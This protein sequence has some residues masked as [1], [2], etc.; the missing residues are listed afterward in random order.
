MQILLD[1]SDYR[2]GNTGDV[3]MLQVAILRLR[4]LWPQARI[5]VVTQDASAL[6]LHCPGVEPL[7]H[8]GRTLWLSDRL[9]LGS[10]HRLLPRVLSRSIITAKKALR[11]TWPALVE[12]A[13]R[14]RLRSNPEALDA[15]LKFAAAFRDSNLVV[16][17]GAGGI[18]D[19][20]ANWA[21]PVMQLLHVAAG[22]RKTTAMFSHGLGPL[23]DSELIE[24]ARSALPKLHLLALREGCY[25]PALAGQ[26]GVPADRTV[27]TG[28]DAIELAYN[29]RRSEPGSGIGFNLRVSSSANTPQSLVERMRP[30]IHD[31][32]TDLSSFLIPLPVSFNERSQRTANEQ[33]L[34]LPDDTDAATLKKLGIGWLQDA[35]GGETLNT[36]AGLI[37]AVG[38]CRIVITGAYHAA[39]FALSQGIPVICLANST[40][41]RDKFSGLIDQFGNHGIILSP[42][43]PSFE[44]DLRDAAQRLWSAAERLRRPLLQAAARQIELGYWAYGKL[45]ESAVSAAAFPSRESTAGAPCSA[46]PDPA[47]ETTS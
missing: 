26:I 22:R 12:Y 43:D 28:D 33:Y 20:A 4:K 31:I 9:I 37:E 35:D 42:A 19:H 16:V 41:F 23:T 18:T 32:A 46:G 38:N 6:A 17:S 29:A 24:Q 44:H 3:A 15:F 5:H 40:Y 10:L 8:A 39:V 11:R 34:A 36:P 14:R 45:A 2:C 13:T 25:G 30:L 7:Q 21:R 27:V 1:T 47:A